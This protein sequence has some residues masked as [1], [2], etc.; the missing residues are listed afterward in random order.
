[1]L[2]SFSDIAYLA[3]DNYCGSQTP[4]VDP[5]SLEWVF[6]GMVVNPSSDKISGQ[7]VQNHGGSASAT[8]WPGLVLQ[9]DTQD[10]QA[11]LGSPN[12]YGTAFLLTTHPVFK[13]QTIIEIHLFNDENSDM[14][15]AFNIGVPKK[16]ARRDVEM[17]AANSDPG[18]FEPSPWANASFAL[19]EDYF[20]DD[21]LMSLYS[22]A[23]LRRSR[24]SSLDLDLSDSASWAS[25]A[26]ST[27]SSSSEDPAESI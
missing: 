7:V 17:L 2:S 10:G 12:G 23:S 27:T 14:C 5:A 15:M 25:S 8:A 18:Q 6:Q 13:G 16:S 24:L 20:D 1:M 21:E 4:K 3:W 22:S 19:N 11:L 9:P 26:A